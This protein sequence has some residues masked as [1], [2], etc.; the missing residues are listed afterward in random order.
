MIKEIYVKSILNKHKRRDEWFLDNYSVN[1]Y[2]LCQFNCVY[3]YIHGSKYGEN[4]S[5]RLAVKINAPTVLEKELQRRA[6]RKEYGFIALSSA[7]E[8][9]MYVEKRYEITRR[10]LEVIAKFKFPVHCLTK[11]T[12][13]LRDLDI[14]E[15]INKNAILPEDLKGKLN[16]GILITISLSTLD[17]DIAKIFEPGAPK[18]KDRLNVLQRIKDE[19]FQAGIAY[20][21]ILPFISDDNE[22]LEEM[23]CTAKDCNADYVFVGTLTLFGIG[24]RIYYDILENHFPELLPKYKQLFV[25]NQPNR[26][27]QNKIEKIIKNM[28]KKFNIKYKIL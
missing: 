14:L 19:G 16:C 10:C 27:Y 25:F 20:I 4:M 2:Q 21:P 17:E 28:C 9:W 5:K 23:I 12:L 7:T 1:P 22:Q 3:C 24:K 11:S 6:R 26:D 8:P 13:I 15:E 18:P